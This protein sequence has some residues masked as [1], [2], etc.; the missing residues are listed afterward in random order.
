MEWRTKT[1]LVCA[2]SLAPSCKISSAAFINP[3][4]MYGI[5]FYFHKKHILWF[6]Q[7]YCQQTVQDTH[8][9]VYFN[10]YGPYTIS[11]P[12]IGRAP[13]WASWRLNNV[14]P[15][16]HC[17][18]PYWIQ[19]SLVQKSFHSP[20]FLPLSLSYCF[21]PPCLSQAL[22]LPAL[23]IA[24]PVVWYKAITRAY[25]PFWIINK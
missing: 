8:P 24:G 13:I 18:R 15:D 14:L 9:V 2:L 20:S 10:F 7:D 3:V 17:K 16:P 12:F 1:F 21:I 6:K 19:I 25:V 4:K 23:F 11:K 22:S 5:V